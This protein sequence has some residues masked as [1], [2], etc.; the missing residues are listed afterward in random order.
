MLLKTL[1]ETSNSVDERLKV[2]KAAKCEE[3]TTEDVSEPVI[4]YDDQLKLLLENLSKNEKLHR[5]T[6]PAAHARP[7]HH[8]AQAE[9]TQ[10]S[11]QGP[12]VYQQP[13]SVSQNQLVTQ[14]YHLINEVIMHPQIMWTRNFFYSLGAMAKTQQ[15]IMLE[16]FN[17]MNEVSHTPFALTKFITET[18][19]L[20]QRD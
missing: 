9:H 14:A 10:P 8:Q 17:E 16:W 6:K 1:V 11:S 2:D 4:S 3:K 12:A 15:Q 5:K 13:S 18:T 20:H 7:E 19:D